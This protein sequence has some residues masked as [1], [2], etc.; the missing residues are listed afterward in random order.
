MYSN[1]IAPV[2]E[3][4]K[5]KNNVCL[6]CFFYLIIG[7]GVTNRLEYAS[8]PFY[9]VLHNHVLYLSY[10]ILILIVHEILTQI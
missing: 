6:Y 9:E 7:L 8:I 4:T 2:P 5:N 10:I 3:V 1:E